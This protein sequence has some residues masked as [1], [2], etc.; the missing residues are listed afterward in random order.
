M[1]LQATTHPSLNCHQAQQATPSFSSSYGWPAAPS[2]SRAQQA[3]LA[4]SSV[5]R[6]ASS[7]SSVD[8]AVY[9]ALGQELST[10]VSQLSPG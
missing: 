1:Q 2:P 7:S 9:N 8:A 10:L 6:A 5:R 4:S 3:T